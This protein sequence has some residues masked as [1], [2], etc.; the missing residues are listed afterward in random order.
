MEAVEEKAQK[1]VDSLPLKIEAN[2]YVIRQA[3]A[4]LLK[5]TR[6][7]CEWHQTDVGSDLWETECGGSFVFNDGPP[8]DNGLKFCGFCGGILL[9]V[10]AI[11]D[12]TED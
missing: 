6:Q 4:D 3:L 9:Q 8:Y 7:P 5:S 2:T 1:F 11:D 12:D 10:R